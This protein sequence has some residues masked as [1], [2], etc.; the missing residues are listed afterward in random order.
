MKVV[1]PSGCRTLGGNRK[2]GFQVT[3]V[4]HHLRGGGEDEG[5][6]MVAEDVDRLTGGVYIFM[7]MFDVDVFF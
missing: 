3:D 7:F 4:K 2:L 5:E 6:Q 1:K